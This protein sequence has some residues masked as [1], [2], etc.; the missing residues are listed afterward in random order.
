MVGPPAKSRSCCGM[1][2]AAFDKERLGP[3]ITPNR[4]RAASTMSA[5]TG[6]YSAPSASSLLKRSPGSEP[7]YAPAVRSS[8]LITL[9]RDG[10]RGLSAVSRAM[11]ALATAKNCDRRNEARSASSQALNTAHSRAGCASVRPYSTVYASDCVTCERSRANVR[12]PPSGVVRR[13]A[14]YSERR[15]L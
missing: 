12:L 1:N 10:L 9:P 11:A 13:Y 8:S 2:A 6:A 4:T 7:V 5:F 15:S 3:T 14:L